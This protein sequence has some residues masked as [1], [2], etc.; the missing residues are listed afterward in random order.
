MAVATVN[1][2]G[3][4]DILVNN[5]GVFPAGANTINTSV[6]DWNRILNINLTGP[7][8]R[9]RLCIPYLQKSGRDSVVNITSVAGIVGG[10]GP[11]YSFSKAAL[12]MLTKDQ[13]IEFA[14]DKIRVNAILP[15]SVLTLMTDFIM[16]HPMHETTI[17]NMC[18]MERIGIP[19][20]IAN[21]A[22]F[23]AGDLYS[24]MTGAAMV[25]DGGLTAR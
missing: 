17:K 2:F 20:E 5:A 19:I 8:I 13:A 24:Y 7:F 22:L 11:D 1:R 12:R 16:K 21:G 3:K 6:E 23:L 9:I 14:K 25:I 18:P 4:I 10:N 15:G